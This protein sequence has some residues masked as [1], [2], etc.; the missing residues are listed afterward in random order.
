MDQLKSMF[1][2]VCPE[3]LL[4]RLQDI[5]AIA[6]E[7]VGEEETGA[8]INRFQQLVE[9]LWNPPQPLPTRKQYE[10]RRKEQMEVESWAGCV[11]LLSDINHLLTL[12]KLMLVLFQELL[13]LAR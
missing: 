12:N 3:H 8:D 13:F 9:N 10:A 7:R 2:D 4:T 5:T 6:E 1:P 11:H